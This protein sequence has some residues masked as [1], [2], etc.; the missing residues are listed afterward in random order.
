MQAVLYALNV[1][2]VLQALTPEQSS[3]G[4]TKCLSHRYIRTASLVRLS[5]TQQRGGTSAAPAICHEEISVSERRGMT[6]AVI[7]IRRE[8]LVPDRYSRITTN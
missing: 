4:S 8:Y 2:E 7:E 5:R 1:I 6:A 3:T